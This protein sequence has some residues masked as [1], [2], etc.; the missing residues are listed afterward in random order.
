MTC[1]LYVNFETMDT[2]PTSPQKG[3][4]GVG[5]VG[6]GELA[7]PLRACEEGNKLETERHCTKQCLATVHLIDKSTT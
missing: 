4:G 1:S 5:L 6:V 7:K 2:T 3:R